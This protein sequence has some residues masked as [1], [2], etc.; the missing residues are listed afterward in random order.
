MARGTSVSAVLEDFGTNVMTAT[1]GAHYRLNDLVASLE[2]ARVRG[3]LDAEVTGIAYDSRRVSPG[4]LFVAVKGE[5]TDGNLYV[6]Q[7]LARG[8]VACVSDQ[9]PTDD[10]TIWI[11]VP[12]ARVGMARL[13]R[14][15]YGDPS[16]ELTLIGITGTKG[17]TTTTY[18]VDSVLATA[19]VVSCRIGTIDY[20]MGDRV[21]SAERTTPEAIE[22]QCMLRESVQSGCTHAVMEVSSHS[23]ALH[24]VQGCRFAVACFTNL[25]RDHLD[26]HTDFE[27]YFGAKQLLF[28][29]NE[30]FGPGSRRGQRQR[31]LGQTPAAKPEL[32]HDDIRPD[33]GSRRASRD[34]ARESEP[35]ALRRAH[36]ARPA[37]DRFA[38]GGFGKP[39]QYPVHGR[40]LSEPGSFR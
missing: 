8:A 26:Y 9:S 12:D 35:A 38:S 13:A 29:G 6:E 39:V 32:P 17:K 21:W 2:G 5:L 7:A 31:L 1:A 10:S 37:A 24:R 20:K 30:V 4:D 28:V 25:S 3:Q 22:L 11:Q 19:G 33:R 15:F 27:N 16:R 34:D 14:A 23:L 36:V 40:D 18:L